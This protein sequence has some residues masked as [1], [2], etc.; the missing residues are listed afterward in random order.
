[1]YPGS[2]VLFSTAFDSASV[3][4]FV[5]K[6]LP[7]SFI[8]N[9]GNRKMSRGPSQAGDGSHVV[10][11]KTFT[12]EKGRGTVRCRDATTSFFVSQVRG[13]VFAHF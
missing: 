7:F 6:W 13:E 9:R 3:T 5:S 1:M 12:G 10:F 11:G 2:R 4:S 8:L